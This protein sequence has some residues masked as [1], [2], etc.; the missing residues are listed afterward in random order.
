[1]ALQAIL[2]KPSG[3]AESMQQPVFVYDDAQADISEAEA[4][5]KAEADAASDFF[6]VDQ[7]GNPGIQRIAPFAVR[8]IVNYRVRQLRKLSKQTIGE[9]RF[10]FEVRAERKVLRYAP[11]VARYPTGPV[12]SG[13][14]P[15][16]NGVLTASRSGNGIQPLGVTIEPPPVNMGKQAVVAIGSVTAAWVNTVSTL[17]GHVNSVAIGPHAAG[18]IMLVLVTVQQLDDDSALV[19]V[20][21]NHKENVTNDSRGSITGITYN[22][23]HY[24]W[25]T[26]RPI[27]NRD[28]GVLVL[29]PQYVYVNE[30]WPTADIT[31]IGVSPPG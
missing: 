25:E 12:I 16:S 22:G 28:G 15:P 4:K 6:G 18:E 8:V 20:G 11:E 7:D 30:V 5:T 1:M 27:P 21:W 31:A 23:H 24:V 26:H 17:I 10:N 29:E 9:E 2:E 19:K 3:N 14:A 13:G